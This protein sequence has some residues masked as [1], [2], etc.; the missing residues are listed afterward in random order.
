MSTSK[1]A[2]AKI[3]R[4]IN[5]LENTERLISGLP[6]ITYKRHKERIEN[7]RRSIENLIT[8]IS[9]IKNRTNK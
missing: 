8:E 7:I 6:K 4:A 1:S 2:G 5:Q 3:Q 9:Y